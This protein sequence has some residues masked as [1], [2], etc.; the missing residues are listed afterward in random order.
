VLEVIADRF[1]NNDKYRVLAFHAFAQGSDDCKKLGITNVAS[2]ESYRQKLA[3]AKSAIR[4]PGRTY[5]LPGGVGQSTYS[6]ESEY[7]SLLAASEKTFAEL[8]RID[9]AFVNGEN[10]RA[11]QEANAIRKALET[12]ATWFG[13]ITVKIHSLEATA[14]DSKGRKYGIP[15]VKQPDK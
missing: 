8:K 10:D 14:K 7:Q 2:L 12:N 15:I 9:D 1:L 4:V 3:L 11:M 5:T 13:P 6:N